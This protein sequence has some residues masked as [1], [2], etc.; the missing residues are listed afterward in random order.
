MSVMKSHVFPPLLFML[1]SQAAF[2]QVEAEESAE[3]TVEKT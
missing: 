3:E 2:A 1:A